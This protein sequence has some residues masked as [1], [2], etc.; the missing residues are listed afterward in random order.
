LAYL[1]FEIHRD[2]ILDDSMEKL[3]R[4]KNNLKNPLKI[5]FI[6]EEGRD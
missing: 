2:N 3:G 5:Q 1:H 6:G 4:I